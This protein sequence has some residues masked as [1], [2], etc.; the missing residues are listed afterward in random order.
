MD[1]LS[2]IP[3]EAWIV[4]GIVLIPG[5]LVY[6]RIYTQVLYWWG[7]YLAHAAPKKDKP[8]RPPTLPYT[9]PLLGSTL[10][11]ATSTTGKF[12]RSLQSTCQSKGLDA[13]CIVLN[14]TPTHLIFSPAAVSSIFKARTLSRFRLDQQLGRNVLGMTAA[15]AAKTFPDDLDAKEQLT[16]ERIHSAALLSTSAVNALT[17]RFMQEFTAQ[18]ARDKPDEEVELYSWLRNHMLR[19]STI[20]LCGSTILDHVPNLPTDFWRWDDGLIGMLF[21]TPRL[22]AKEAY[23]ARDRLLDGLT[24]WLEAGYAATAQAE[25]TDVDWEPHFGARVM[26]KRHEYYAQQRL[27]LRTQA[28]ADLI[29]LGG[30]LSNAIP[31]TGWLLM[32]LLDPGTD[33]DILRDVLAELRTAERA[34]GT[35]DIATLTSL[36]LLNST[37]H[38]VLRLYVDLL[39][40]RQV[41]APTTLEAYSVGAGEMVMAP[42]WMVHRNPAFFANPDTFQ[43]RRF[44]VTD[45]EAGKVK[46]DVSGLGGKYFPFGGG[47]Y[48]CP[49]RTFAKQ[50][51]LGAV[52]VV[53]LGNDV[54][55]KGFKDGK[56]FPRLKN[57]LAGNVVV[58]L[59]GDMKVKMKRRRG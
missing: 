24:G 14:A 11:F 4:W 33:D 9:I 23:D 7:I 56:G 39:V 20:S 43:P 3:T 6:T 29:F 31:A 5:W 52:A 53:L 50:E 51:V 46:C 12:W 55:V 45:P 17:S 2:S 40:T 16:T 49:G 26:H 57:G 30:I 41:D 35:I 21:G 58:G 27:T 36:P 38:E 15:E 48:M 44:L 32:H 28:G 1:F 59:E 47:H 42:T 8:I 19:A 34:D 13:M 37:F 10:S 18:L 54:E 25:S 22:F